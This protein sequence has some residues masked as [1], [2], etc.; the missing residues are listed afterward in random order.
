L[1]IADFKQSILDCALQSSIGGSFAG[2][3]IPQAISAA[4]LHSAD[5]QTRDNYFGRDRTLPASAAAL[6][7]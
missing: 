5:L 3:G 6:A 2:A 1:V 4:L 7:A